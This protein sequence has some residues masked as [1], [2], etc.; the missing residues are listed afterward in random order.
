MSQ[1]LI[2]R[3]AADIRR[4]WSWRERRQRALASDRRCMELLVRLVASASHRG[5]YW[6]EKTSA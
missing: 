2:K 3:R 5:A 1:E 4:G 6:A